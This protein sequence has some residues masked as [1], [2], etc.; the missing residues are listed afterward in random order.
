MGQVPNRLAALS[1]QEQSTEKV[2]IV[3]VEIVLGLLKDMLFNLY[4]HVVGKERVELLLGEPPLYK[5]TQDTITKESD[6][7]ATGKDPDGEIADQENNACTDAITDHDAQLTGPA[8]SPPRP[9][10]VNMSEFRK[11]IKDTLTSYN[12]GDRGS[13]GD[14]TTQSEASLD[15]ANSVTVSSVEQHSDDTKEAEPEVEC[16]L[17]IWKLGPR[18]T[19][20]MGTSSS[21]NTTSSGGSNFGLKKFGNLL[22][23]IRKP[24]GVG[25]ALAKVVPHTELTWPPKL[26]IT[27]IS[28]PTIPIRLPHFKHEV[29]PRITVLISRPEGL[30]EPPRLYCWYEEQA[31][32]AW[33]NER[34]DEAGNLIK[35][36]KRE[37]GEQKNFRKEVNSRYPGGIATWEAHYGGRTFTGVLDHD[38]FLKPRRGERPRRRRSN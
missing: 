18:R 25:H 19:G 17:S 1:S 3:V 26:V 35:A 30:S 31:R 21:E 28:I 7:E 14:S 13:D 24:T 23:L 2:D 8:T 33:S 36:K 37:K 5:K 12:Y 9:G 4:E 6:E 32:D 29:H 34:F 20:N 10:S 22:K 27:A 38:G 11:K 15:G 16:A